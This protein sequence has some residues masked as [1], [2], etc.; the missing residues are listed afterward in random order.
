[1]HVV[2]FPHPGAEFPV[3]DTNSDRRPDGRYDV[4]WNTGGH[5]RRLVKHAGR[6]VDAHGV[7]QKGDLL[8]WTEWEGCTTATRLESQNGLVNAHD[9]HEVVYPVYTNN[10]NNAATCSQNTDPCV[11]GRTFKYSNCRQ[12]G[13]RCT[14]RNLQQG[15]LV[16]FVSMIQDTYC[17]DTVFVVDTRRDYLTDNTNTVDCSAEYRTLTLDRLPAHQNFTFYR[18]MTCS[19]NGNQANALFSFTPVRLYSG[20]GNQQNFARC[21]LDV[22]AVNKAVGRDVFTHANLRNINTTALSAQEIRRVWTEI[23]RQVK[24]QGFVR[25]VSFDWPRQ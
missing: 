17:L 4:H 1:M 22:D 14:L 11:F 7:L 18:G 12:R 21:A 24:E 10:R 8:F 23:S 19:G 13:P 6:Y 25:G 16:A 20:L 2:Q 15:S 5:H 3:R 9:L